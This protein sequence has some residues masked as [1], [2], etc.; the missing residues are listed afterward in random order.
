MGVGINCVISVYKFPLLAEGVTTYGHYT[1]VYTGANTLKTRKSR[2]RPKSTI[3]YTNLVA[4]QVS[5]GV[6]LGV[7]TWG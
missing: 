7:D 6:G 3:V 1:G 2:D 4:S 5:L